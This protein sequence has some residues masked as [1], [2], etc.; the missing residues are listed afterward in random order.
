MH[1]APFCRVALSPRLIRIQKY[2]VF[3]SE[4]DRLRALQAREAA[5]RLA[6]FGDYQSLR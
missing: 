4:R 3:Q 1:C 6:M 2:P 5:T